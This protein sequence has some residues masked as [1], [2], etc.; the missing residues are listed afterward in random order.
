MKK[1]ILIVLSLI[2]LVM[3]GC[4]SGVEPNERFEE[5]KLVGFYL[6]DDYIKLFFGSIIN[7]QKIHYGDVEVDDLEK[8]LGKDAVY[9]FIRGSDY[10]T[11]LEINSLSADEQE[12]S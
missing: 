10:D 5:H 1:V 9:H 11:L 7:S 4:S 6:Y 2:L 12:K 3:C 8:W